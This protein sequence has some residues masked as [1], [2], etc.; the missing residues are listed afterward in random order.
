M[1]INTFTAAVR[2][3]S[4]FRVTATSMATNVITSVA[5][6]T[7]VVLTAADGAEVLLKWA[8][9]KTSKKCS[10]NQANGAWVLGGFGEC[11]P[12]EDNYVALDNSVKDA[13][14]Q[15]VLRFNAEFKENENENA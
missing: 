7:R 2:T 5:S 13:W 9:V 14:G 12:Y 3:V 8:W 15:P 10:L 11:L 6:A 4:I 1:M